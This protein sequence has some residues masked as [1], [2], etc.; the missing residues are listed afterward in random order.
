MACK[1]LFAPIK[2]DANTGRGQFTK[3]KTIEL[4]EKRGQEAAV[5]AVPFCCLWPYLLF[6]FNFLAVL[7]FWKSAKKHNR[8]FKCQ[9]EA[10]AQLCYS[11]RP[12]GPKTESR[13]IEAQSKWAFHLV[14]CNVSMQHSNIATTTTTTI[15]CDSS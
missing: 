2:S 7:K 15:S 4:M 10:E 13:W 1:N 11:G 8:L 14:L 3:K 9:H 12:A 6:P 5:S